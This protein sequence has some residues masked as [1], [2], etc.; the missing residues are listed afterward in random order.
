MSV[1]PEVWEDENGN[2]I[3]YDCET[4]AAAF[5]RLIAYLIDGSHHWGDRDFRNTNTDLLAYV[6]DF[7]NY[8]PYRMVGS[9]DVDELEII[10]ESD[11][12]YESAIP[13]FIVS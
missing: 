6:T 7:N 13:L 1:A 5:Q 4:T 2:F 3:I 12:R 9:V 10:S 11:P 8:H